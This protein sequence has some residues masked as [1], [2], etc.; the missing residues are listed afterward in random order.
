MLEI[1]KTF[2][3][4]DTPKSCQSFWLDTNFNYRQLFVLIIIVNVTRETRLGGRFL[5]NQTKS[6]VSIYENKKF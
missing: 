3:Y 2:L 6:H 4:L 5:N 1:I